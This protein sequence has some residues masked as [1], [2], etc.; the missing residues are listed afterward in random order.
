L[1]KKVKDNDNNR[2]ANKENENARA[3]PSKQQRASDSY[4][5]TAAAPQT[6]VIDKNL[7]CAFTCSSLL[8]MVLF[9]FEKKK[10][11]A[12]IHAVNNISPR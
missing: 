7:A 11:F 9:F 12:G 6:Y 10:E 4:K 3:N 1:R 5:E 2:P 8:N